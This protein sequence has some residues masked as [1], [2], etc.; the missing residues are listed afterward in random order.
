MPGMHPRWFY[1]E[2]VTPNVYAQDARPDDMRA[3]VNAVL[4]LGRH[5]IMLDHM[6]RSLRRRDTGGI[7]WREASEG[8]SDRV[9]KVADRA[10]GFGSEDGL[11]LG[12]GKFDRVEVGGGRPA[13]TAASL[14]LP[15]C[16]RGCR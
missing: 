16:V 15:R 12:E 7:R 11:E 9:P 5:P 1:D 6:R 10:S 3:V 14:R 8:L 2:V 4:T 13:G